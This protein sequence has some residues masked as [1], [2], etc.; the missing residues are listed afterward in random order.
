MPADFAAIAIMLARRRHAIDTPRQ[1]Q[2]Q[3]P[4]LY[5]LIHFI[6][7]IDISTPFIAFTF[8]FFAAASHAEL[9]IRRCR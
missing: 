2:P 6:T 3:M 4:P 9:P 1:L 5:A 7:S 8:A